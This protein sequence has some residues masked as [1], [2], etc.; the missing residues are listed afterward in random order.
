VA[1]NGPSFRALFNRALL[2][3]RPHELWTPTPT[4]P[5]AALHTI[6]GVSRIVQ[7]SL[8]LAFEVSTEFEAAQ[9]PASMSLK[10]RARSTGKPRTDAYI[11]ATFLIE[12]A[13]M[14]LLG[15][16]SGV[17]TA[18]RAAGQAVLSRDWL[19]PAVFH[20]VYAFVEPEIPFA[21]LDAPSAE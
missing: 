6:A 10:A 18:V 12:S 7:I 15:T 16:D 5:S 11:D 3:A 17:A 21:D 19:A 13:L 1:L 2:A 20:D 9:P 4:R 14:P 8:A